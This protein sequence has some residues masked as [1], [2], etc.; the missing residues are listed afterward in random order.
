MSSTEQPQ[1]GTGLPKLGE[2]GDACAR[3]GSVLAT[4]Q[5]YC[6]SC[7][8]RRAGPRLE[9]EP[10]QR[11]EMAAQGAAAAGS[12]QGGSGRREW[13]PIAYVGSIAVLGVMLLLGVLIGKD[14]DDTTV[15][16]P[17]PTVAVPT[18]PTTPTPPTSTA[19][20]GTTPP[21]TNPATPATPAPTTPTGTTPDSG[22][23]SPPATE[24]NKAK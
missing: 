1:P 15:T 13:S 4:D 14:D 8:Q 21:T 2:E 17:A 5:R 18:V 24:G 19:P 3:C 10:S 22:A 7:G 9:F 16:T 23:V 11:E 20:T 6:L 12:E